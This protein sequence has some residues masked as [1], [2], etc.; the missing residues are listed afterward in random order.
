MTII[1]IKSRLNKVDVKNIQKKKMERFQ[2]TSKIK[3]MKG[4]MMLK[5]KED[6]E[7][8]NQLEYKQYKAKEANYMKNIK[9]MK[10]MKKIQ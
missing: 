1:I 5:D 9:K 7:P 3:N 10:K 4:K 6:E 8:E 2:N